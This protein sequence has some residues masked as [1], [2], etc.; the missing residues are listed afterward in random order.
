MKIFNI[1]GSISL[2]V[3]LATSCAVHD[4]FDDNM[5]IGQVVPTV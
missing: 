5:D 2:L 1:L 4:P 3:A